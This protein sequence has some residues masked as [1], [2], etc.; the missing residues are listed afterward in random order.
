MQISIFTGVFIMS[1]HD[2]P[3]DIFIVVGDIFSDISK[4]IPEVLTESEAIDRIQTEICP[5][6][7]TILAIGQGVDHHMIES[8]QLRRTRHQPEFSNK[9]VLRGTDTMPRAV[10][11][12]AHKEKTANILTS[13][14]EQLDDATY[15]LDLHF[16]SS[17]EFFGDHMTGMHIQGMALTEAARQAFLVVTE[18]HYLKDEKNEHYFVIK[19]FNS[20]YLNF[21]FPLNA[22]L[23]YRVVKHAKKA[24][25][26]SFEVVMTLLQAG[27]VCAEFDV[28][29]TAFEKT[30]ISERETEVF[31]ERLDA[32][33]TS[34]TPMPAIAAASN[35]ATASARM[36][37]A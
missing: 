26:Q 21:V 8:A 35:A 4:L 22:S 34:L 27:K 25:Y 24:A 5:T 13:F 16:A 31:R 3:T 12:L 7:Q 15:R 18:E 9:F 1:S 36:A 33:I 30:R 11:R 10:K 29:F 37:E 28:A 2:L 6:Q 17:N 19:S 23:E 20:K 32:M 14:A